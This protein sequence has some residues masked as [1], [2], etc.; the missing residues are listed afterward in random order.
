MIVGKSIYSANG[1]IL[2]KENVSMTE[3]YLSQLGRLEIPYI[4]IKDGIDDDIVVDDLIREENR[5]EAV[6]ITRQVI[7]KVC[8]GEDLNLSVVKTTINKIVDDLANN[9]NLVLNLVDI[10]AQDDYLYGHSVNVA[11]LSGIIGL[12]LNYN[13]I[14]LRDLM[15]GALLH[16]IGRAKSGQ[17]RDANKNPV[18]PS[19]NIQNQ[20][21]CREGFD[22]LRASNDISLHSAHVA[23]QHHEF[24]NGN[25]Y[26]RGL[27]GQEISEFARIV[28][29][30]N[31]YDTFLTKPREKEET[32]V[33]KA[34]EYLTANCG[35][36]FDP[37]LVSIFLKKVAIYP[38]G[39]RVTLNT[40]EKGIVVENHENFPTQPI[41]RVDTNLFGLALN[42]CYD[43]DLSSKEAYFIISHEEDL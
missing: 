29:I 33:L 19:E 11:V 16:D 27:R 24:F 32:S 31:T 21:H 5:V 14:Q 20:D 30:A 1:R 15:I 37:E 7:E 43:V 41:V 23:F 9:P 8:R 2:L 39:T 35:T 36:I 6:G 3:A 17:K 4:Y 38:I 18:N 22:I 42:G 26:P 40:G 13:E 28:S 10:R 34:V 25:G 12:A